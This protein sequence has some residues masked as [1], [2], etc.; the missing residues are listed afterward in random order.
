MSRAEIAL[1]HFND[2]KEFMNSRIN[3]GI[4]LYRKGYS[5]IKITDA[6]GNPIKGLPFK[7]KQKNHYFNFG[8]NL[9]MLDEFETEEKCKQYREIFPKIFNYAVVPFYW[10]GIEP[11]KGKKRFDA[12]S[13]KFYRRPAADLVTKFCQENNI[14]MKAH[15]LVYDKFT[16]KWLPKDTLELKKLI[17]S[18]MEEIAERYGSIIRD[19]DIVNE[20]LAWNC[21]DVDY[22]SK[23]FREEDYVTYPFKVA[24]H[25]PFERKFINDSDG[26]W[27]NFHFT[28]SY[29]YL[30][31]RDLE[32]RGVDFDAIGLQ[33]HQFVP[34]E[35]EEEYA[36][37]RYNPMRVFDVLDTFG[38][39]KKPIHLSEITISAYSNSDEDLAIQAELAENMYKIWFSQKNVDAIIYWNLI[40]GYTAGSQA[41]NMTAGE[42]KFCGSLLNFD[43]SPKPAFKAIEQL[44]N[45]EWHT[46]GVFGTNDYGVANINGFKGD[47]DLEFSYNGKNYTKSIKLDGRYD[48]INHIVLD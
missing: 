10:E 9:F 42:N 17:R 2:Q 47:Y 30:F 11:E 7:A 41:N 6:K 29:F 34:R 45:H 12:D 31:L 13:P 3:S 8:C 38:D 22:V 5:K 28:R 18:H 35:K 15:C 37:N 20:A 4:E 25:L 1:K 44:I 26:I 46:E 33:F 40:D 14:R 16:P 27:E 39:F 23:F 48:C 19:W 21:Y 32:R 24:K 36:L 43:L